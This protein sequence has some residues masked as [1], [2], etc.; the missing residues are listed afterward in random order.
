MLA[1][2]LTSMV[3]LG[4]FSTVVVQKRIISPELHPDRSVTFRLKAPG[5]S[6]VQVSL[7]GG[8]PLAMTK[9]EDGIWSA[10]TNPLTPDL[11]GYT[12]SVDGVA[13]LDPNNPMIKPNL[14]Y[15]GNMVLV[16]G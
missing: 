9:S 16:P 1:R 3:C 15:V 6:T 12:F 2:M 10:T 11:Y 5:A 8:K 7:E 4:V 13:L 14:I